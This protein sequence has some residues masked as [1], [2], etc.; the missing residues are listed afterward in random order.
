MGVTL[1]NVSIELYADDNG[2]GIADGPLVASTLTDGDTGNYC[3]EDVTPG[4][5]VIVQIQPVNYAS[6]QDFDLT[7]GAFD[8][9][10]ND[11]LQTPDN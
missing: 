3:F 1:S 9:D 11:S 2:D 10:G 5:Y 4:D 6:V 7:T 8:P